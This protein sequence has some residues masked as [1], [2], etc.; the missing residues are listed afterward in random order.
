MV[1]DRRGWPSTSIVQHPHDACG[2]H[3]FLSDMQPKSS[4]STANNDRPRAF[5][6]TVFSFR[7]NLILA[8]GTDSTVEKPSRMAI[9]SPMRS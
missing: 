3:P 1:H 4:R 6:S 2:S 7:L 9:K 8:D 5:V